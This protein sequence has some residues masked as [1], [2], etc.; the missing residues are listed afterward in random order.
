[1]S[2]GNHGHEGVFICDERHADFLQYFLG[3]GIGNRNYIGVIYNVYVTTV[4]ECR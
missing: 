2:K 1:M 4:P 3:L